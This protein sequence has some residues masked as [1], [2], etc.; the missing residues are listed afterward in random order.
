ME[1]GIGSHTSHLTDP[2]ALNALDD[3]LN[4]ELWEVWRDFDV[5][6]SVDVA[7]LTRFWKSFLLGCRPEDLHPQMGK[8]HNAGRSQKRG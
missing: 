4:A 6:R 7:I 8:S 1:N 2:D 3:D 5:D